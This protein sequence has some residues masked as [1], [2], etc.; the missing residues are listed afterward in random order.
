MSRLHILG[1]KFPIAE[2]APKKRAKVEIIPD[3]SLTAIH[4]VACMLMNISDV[5]YFLVSRTLGQL[6]GYFTLIWVMIRLLTS[7]LA[8]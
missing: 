8:V 1:L 2:M 5:Y 7:Y 6:W 3:E 4:Q